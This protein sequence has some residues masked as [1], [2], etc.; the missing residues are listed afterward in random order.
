MQEKTEI[1]YL[2]RRFNDMC[3]EDQLTVLALVNS[4][5]YANQLLAT[6]SESGG[7]KDSRPAD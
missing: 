7:V 2:V 5:A 1:D 4:R 6:R 3:R